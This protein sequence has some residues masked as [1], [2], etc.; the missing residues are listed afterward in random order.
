MSASLWT[1]AKIMLTR[2][3]PVAALSNF[4]LYLAF[5]KTNANTWVDF[6][7]S[8]NH[9]LIGATFCAANPSLRSFMS[10]GLIGLWAGRLC[11]HI[12][13]NRV[14]KGENDP[15]YEK[16]AEKSLPGY[17]KT[18]FFFQFMI[19]ALIVIAPAIPLYY[20]FNGPKQITWNFVLGAA[21]MLGS[22]AMETIADR[23][24]EAFKEE[25]KID[26]SLKGKLCRTG[27]WSKSRHPNLF[28]DFMAWNGASLM[29]FSSL[30]SWPVIIGP[31]SL[32]FIMVHL[33][34]PITEKIMRQN[35]PNWSQEIQ[36]T[37]IFFPF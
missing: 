28:F 15:R 16:M 33:T 6:G 27:L 18:Y 37:N 24:L 23:Q 22:L 14:S 29:G 26:P 35:R 34:I 4:A 13:L 3:L 17:R 31:V 32:Y 25:R 5:L 30:G 10:L 12:Y 36:G 20:I 21:V 8:L 19:Q 2:A 9:F 11:S 1:V 7:W